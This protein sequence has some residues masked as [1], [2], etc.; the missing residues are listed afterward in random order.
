M[1]KQVNYQAT[2]NKPRTE[3][4]LTIHEV[5]EKTSMGR[6]FIFN[7]MAAGRIRPIKMGRVNRFVESEIDQWILDRI[8]SR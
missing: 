2:T 8:A 5:M 3:R 7:E 4:L 6:S 1:T